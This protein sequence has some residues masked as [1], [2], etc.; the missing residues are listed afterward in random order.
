MYHGVTIG[1]DDREAAE[2]RDALAVLQRLEVVNV[3]E[4]LANF[5]VSLLKAELAVRDLAPKLPID[6]GRLGSGKFCSA[7]PL[8]PK[9]VVDKCLACPTLHGSDDLVE[10]LFGPVG[11]RDRLRRPPLEPKLIKVTCLDALVLRDQSWV[12]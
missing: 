3:R 9:A 2:A 6:C 8:F 12:E 7:K 1:A 10:H 11:R 4:T 5:A